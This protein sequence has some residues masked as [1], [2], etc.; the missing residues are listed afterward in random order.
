MKPLAVGGL[1]PTLELSQAARRIVAVRV[2]E[3]YSLGPVAL[4]EDDP[5]A[6]HDLRI[7]AKRLRY[8][9][10]VV[11][12]CLDESAAEAADR[13]RQLQ[14]V[15]G[16]IHD[17]DVLLSRVAKTHDAGRKGTRRLAARLSERRAASFE[18]FVELWSAIDAAGLQ[19]R[20]LS[21]TNHSLDEPPIGA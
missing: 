5:T 21:A 19:A 6:L 11:G 16:E 17:Y 20:L 4:N 14:T 10:D 2:S 13:V 9:L 18:Q 7:A 1:E 8:V 12:F 15:I 3:L